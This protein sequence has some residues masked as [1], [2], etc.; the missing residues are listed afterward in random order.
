[1]ISFRNWS[2]N[3]AGRMTQVK[4]T[5]TATSAVSTIVTNYDGDGEAVRVYE[6]ANIV[7]SDSYMVRSS[8]FGGTVTRLNNAGNKVKTTVNVDDRLIAMQYHA[9]PDYMIWT[10]TD[11]LGLSEA[12]DTKSVYDPM[13]NFINWQP[14]PTGPPPSSY[15]RSSASFGGLGSLFGSAQDKSCIFNDLPISCEEL[16]HKIDIGGVTAVLHGKEIPLVPLGLGM[17]Q[18]SLAQDDK[19]EDPLDELWDYREREFGYF[20]LPMVPQDTRVTTID[21]AGIRGALDLMLRKGDCGKFIEELINRLAADTKNPFLSDYALDLFDSV[22]GAKKGGFVRGGLADKYHVGA[23]S[24]GSIRS[25]NA[26]IHINSNFDGVFEPQVEAKAIIATDAFNTLHEL[27]HHAG[28]KNY[29]SDIQI[30]QTLSKWLG[31]PGLPTRK[32]GESQWDF[33][34]RN[35]SYFSSVLREKCPTLSVMGNQLR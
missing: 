14:A 26:A 5:V 10:H 35:S 30:A 33:I 9:A 23:T 29:Y 19:P 20:I 25:G 2:Y 12:G 31:V 7:N 27:V 32:K 21:P 1:M 6:P 3:A 28:S 8:V 34:G 17:F 18:F 4:E 24:D 11:P 16:A 13:G 15:P 22:N